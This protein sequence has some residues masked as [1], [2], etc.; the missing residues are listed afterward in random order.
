MIKKISIKSILM[1]CL[2]AIVA[3]GGL[4][5]NQMA[6]EAKDFHPQK[7]RCVSDRSMES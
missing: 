1:I 6:P 2:L 7:D 4:R 3:C 5:F